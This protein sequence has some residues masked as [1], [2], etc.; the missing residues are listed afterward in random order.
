MHQLTDH[1]LTQ[2]N[3]YISNTITTKTPTSPESFAPT[4][5]RAPTQPCMSSPARQS[6]ATGS[7]QAPTP[8]RMQSPA[9]EPLAP[10]SPQTTHPRISSP[11]TP[12]PEPPSVEDRLIIDRTGTHES[13]HQVW[14]NDFHKETNTNLPEV[15]ELLANQFEDIIVNH[16]PEFAD[17]ALTRITPPG[18][19]S[20][21]F[22]RFFVSTGNP[23]HLQ[24]D[25]KPT[26]T[27]I[28]YAEFQSLNQIHQPKIK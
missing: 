13:V 1:G 25:H 4:S 18:S 2:F 27:K 6:N 14:F 8:P 20:S 7:P 15:E 9:P 10:S 5:P 26:L 23:I 3:N 24:L 21:E 22:D 17:A 11:D 16:V 19:P 28:S 12:T